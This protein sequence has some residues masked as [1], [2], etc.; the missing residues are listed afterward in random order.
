MSS[1]TFFKDTGVQ[2]FG[3]DT[4]IDFRFNDT[5]TGPY[6]GRANLQFAFE[7]FKNLED[8]LI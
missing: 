8:F 6:D 7:L 3:N 2:F 1:Y 5:D 4:T